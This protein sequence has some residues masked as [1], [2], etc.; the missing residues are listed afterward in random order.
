MPQA[1][2]KVT[3]QSLHKVTKCAIDESPKSRKDANMSALQEGM[4]NSAGA[5]ES[6]VPFELEGGSFF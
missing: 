4:K 2:S 5:T 6:S 1:D 3:P